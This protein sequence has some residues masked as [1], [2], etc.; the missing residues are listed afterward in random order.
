MVMFFREEEENIYNI[1]TDIY[2]ISKCSISYPG[3]LHIIKRNY[4]KYANEWRLKLE[5]YE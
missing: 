4:N 5:E 2:S 1:H 3:S